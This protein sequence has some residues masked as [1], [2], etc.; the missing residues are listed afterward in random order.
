MKQ[1]LSFFYIIYFAID[2]YSSCQLT[3]CLRNVKCTNVIFLNKKTTISLLEIFNFYP[4]PIPC[5]NWDKFSI[6]DIFDKSHWCNILQYYTYW[7]AEVVGAEVVPHL[8]WK[9]VIFVIV[10]SPVT[11]NLISNGINFILSLII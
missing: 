2:F 11:I 8:S 4:I 7:G 1:L 9:N 6:F 10:S 5:T 3:V